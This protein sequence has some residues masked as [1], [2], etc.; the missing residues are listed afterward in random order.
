MRQLNLK[1]IKTKYSYVFY[2]IIDNIQLVEDYY[3]P[4]IIWWVKNNT[5]YFKHDK[6]KQHL[7]CNY[8]N[9]WSILE[10]EY[11]SNYTEIKELIQAVLT[12]EFNLGFLKPYNG[13]GKTC[14]LLNN[15]YAKHNKA[16]LRI[17]NS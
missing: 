12:K 7:I 17:L 8:S 4:N 1:K 6:I 11:N 2:N 5:W 16:R 14:K 9:A 13:E 15:K 3:D 10:S